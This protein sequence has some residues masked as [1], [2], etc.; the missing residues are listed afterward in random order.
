MLGQRRIFGFLC[1]VPC[2]TPSRPLGRRWRA[3][4]RFAMANATFPGG[5][6]RFGGSP[7]S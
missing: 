3:W 5:W 7:T 1:L 4:F 2:R 6:R